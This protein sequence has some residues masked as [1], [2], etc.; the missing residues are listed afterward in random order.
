VQLA[1]TVWDG[2]VATV[3]DFA[4]RLLLVDPAS[5][6]RRTCD[7]PGPEAAAWCARLAAER[8]GTLVCS[9]I[10]RHLA[11]QLE[12]AG[13]TVIDSCAGTVEA[14]IADWLAGTI[15]QRRRPLPGCRGWH[16]G[17]AL[18]AATTPRPQEATMPI[19]ISSAGPGLDDELDPR[20]GRCRHILVCAEGAEPVHHANPVQ[21]AEH[22]AGIRTAEFVA[23][24]GVKTVLTG[25]VGPKAME[26]L[27][28]AGIRAYAS[29]PGSVREA[30]ARLRA[31][32]L[33][34][35]GT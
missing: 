21:G 10:T 16:G 6:G 11:R 7:A 14:V 27:R 33:P 15:D 18:A 20:F 34:E 17:A 19:A 1:I 3:A 35:A 8:V 12:A 9:A 13:I 25:A 28:A 22:G 30:L 31:G 5:G 29:G 32:A 2:Q 24:L 4:R 26:V 23:G